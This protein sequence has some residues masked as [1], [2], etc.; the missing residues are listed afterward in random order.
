MYA[1]TLR[2][3]MTPWNNSSSYMKN[4]DENLKQYAKALNFPKEY[5]SKAFCQIRG[6]WFVDDN[7]NI[8]QL[9]S[10]NE[11]LNAIENS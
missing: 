9:S 7:V 2:R 5:R 6:K 3:L 11:E 8:L 10:Q 4:L 1:E